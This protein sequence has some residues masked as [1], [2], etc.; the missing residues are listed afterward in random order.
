MLIII[1]L[2]KKKTTSSST[3][4]SFLGK[5]KHVIVLMLE[6]RSFDHFFGFSKPDLFVNGLTGKEYNLENVKDKNSKKVFVSKD[7]PYI[8][9]CDPDH[10]TPATKEKVKDG[11]SGFV[12]Y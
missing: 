11:M 5:I 8:N 1:I 12:S 6:N 9:E 2:L 4:N 3:K 10:S 7:A